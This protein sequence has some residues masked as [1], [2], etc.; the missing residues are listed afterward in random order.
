MSVPLRQPASCHASV[1]VLVSCVN[2]DAA[3]VA[4]WQ[5]STGITHKTRSPYLVS[6]ELILRA[7]V[8]EKRKADANAMSAAPTMSMG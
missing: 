1:L 7:E 5:R 6:I 8:R 4:R 3:E 2:E